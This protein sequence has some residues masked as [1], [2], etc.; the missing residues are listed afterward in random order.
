MKRRELLA[1]SIATILASNLRAGSFSLED[2]S[3]GL[4]G[5]AVDVEQQVASSAGV[6]WAI[7]QAIGGI[8]AEPSS[9]TGYALKRKVADRDVD[10]QV[11]AI[12]EPLYRT[13]SRIDLDWRIG[14]VND[15][16]INAYTYG[17]GVVFINSGLILACEKEEELAGVIAHEI[18]HVDYAHAEKGTAARQLLQS[19][20]LQEMARG[21]RP[22]NEVVSFLAQLNGIAYKGYRRLNEHEADAFIVR[23]FNETDYDVHQSSACSEMMLRMFGK[24][25]PDQLTCLFRS[26]PDTLERLQRVRSIQATYSNRRPPRATGD[27]AELKERLTVYLQ[28]EGHGLV[29]LE[30]ATANAIYQAAIKAA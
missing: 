18:G 16:A 19:F 3:G 24:H 29:A 5:V 26:H 22:V 1:G 2:V 28:R 4:G 13:S 10:R 11:S 9:P 23:A 27:F 7:Y 20:S 21:V 30:K 12:F 15:P 17:A 8:A 14:V 6:Q 25:Q